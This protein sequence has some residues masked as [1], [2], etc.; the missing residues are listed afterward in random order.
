MVRSTAAEPVEPFPVV[1]L[2][3]GLGGAVLCLV[4]AMIAVWKTNLH[5]VVAPKLR[6]KKPNDEPLKTFV[7]QEA[8][9]NED[10]DPELV[11]NPVLMAHLALE[12]DR[13]ARKG[14]EAKKGSKGKA[15]RSGGLRRLGLNIDGSKQGA[16]RPKTGKE[17]VDAHLAEQRA[18]DTAVNGVVQPI[19]GG[20]AAGGGAASQEEG[21]GQAKAKVRFGLVR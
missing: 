4:C 9:P 21:R 13:T 20:E 12:E 1:F 15:G 2:V 8:V 10:E 19:A 14:K 18:R 17:L 7:T 5:K 3:A 11:M 6:R 16:S